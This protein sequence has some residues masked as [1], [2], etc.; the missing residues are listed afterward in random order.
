M[1]NLLGIK[2]KHAGPG[3]KR[4][5]YHQGTLG[6]LAQQELQYLHVFPVDSTP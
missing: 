6:R 4:M 2:L 1:T 3:R 5:S